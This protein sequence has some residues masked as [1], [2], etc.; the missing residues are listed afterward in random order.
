MSLHVLALGTY[1]PAWYSAYA[2]ASLT[3]HVY[4]HLSEHESVYSYVENLTHT[5]V[6]ICPIMCNLL[7]SD[8]NTWE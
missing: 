8:A 1:E 3:I 2:C 6:R 7:F 4:V 5:S